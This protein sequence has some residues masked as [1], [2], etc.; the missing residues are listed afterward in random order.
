MQFYLHTL[1]GKRILTVILSLIKF[2]YIEMDN[3]WESDCESHLFKL[4]DALSY[5]LGRQRVAKN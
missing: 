2:D 3:E 1:C 5:Y 4:N